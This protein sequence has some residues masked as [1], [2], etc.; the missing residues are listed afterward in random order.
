MDSFKAKQLEVKLKGRTL[1]GY[2]IIE[3][4]NNG[5]SAA[6]FKAIKN[7]IEYAIKVF[8]NDLIE[9]F[10]H[11]IQEQRIEQELTLQNHTIENLIKIYDGA[12]ENI[13]DEN[14]YFIV[15]EFID[16]V[17]LKQFLLK[18]NYDIVF[19]HQILTSLIQ[20]TEE[21][22]KRGIVH[23]DIKPENIMI[24]K[25]RKLILMDLGV[26]KFIGAK[27]IS[28]E[29]EKQFVGTLR[30]APPEFLTRDEEDS[31]NGWRA[32]NLYQIGGVLHDLITKQELFA[33][34]VP[35]PNLVLSIKEKN[36]KIESN[37]YPH[38]L[39]QLSRN[40]L[41]KN[42]KKRLE[43]C[44]ISSMINSVSNYKPPISE[45]DRQIE[46]IRKL[47][48]AHLSIY[49]E[50]QNIKSNNEK[51]EKSKREN[52]SSIMQFIFQ[53][54]NLLPQ[55]IFVTM[56]DLKMFQ[57]GPDS[58]NQQYI[59]QNRLI[60]ITGTL[61]MGYSRYFYILIRVTNDETMFG[62]IELLGILSKQNYGGEPLP[63]F[64][65]LTKHRNKLNSGDNYEKG[66]FKTYKI[67]EGVIELDDEFSNVVKLG[68][69]NL[70]KNGLSSMSSE[71]LEEMERE[72]NMAQG[73]TSHSPKPRVSNYS[74]I[75][76]DSI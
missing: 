34:A 6:V 68:I 31:E 45:Y 22:I 76:I 40:L 11:E 26:L 46:A 67:F 69:V 43:I 29:E 70:I 13:G 56:S 8:D 5:K 1:K 41:T 60:K 16:G 15:L 4:I 75:I 51:K 61:E 35:Y 73:I 33:E 7:N 50:I 18:E 63:T 65:F 19:I 59:I 72:K 52:A 39:I 32:V 27:S 10:G 53:C 71:V 36:P 25:D 57:F 62:K 37:A 17:N 28:D 20:V 12:K 48:T 30:Y 21:L 44:Q 47:T 58:I 14:Y 24:T 66:R 64:L 9:R 2:N 38:Q 42:W 54:F 49:D 23:R 3:L 55:G 74:S